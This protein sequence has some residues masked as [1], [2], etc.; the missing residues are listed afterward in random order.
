[1]WGSEIFFQHLHILLFMVQAILF[2]ASIYSLYRFFKELNLQNHDG[3]MQWMATFILLSLIS[4][5]VGSILVGWD[6]KTETSKAVLWFLE[7][8]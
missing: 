1:M 8:S 6:N 2:L 5:M 7:R 3:E 4:L